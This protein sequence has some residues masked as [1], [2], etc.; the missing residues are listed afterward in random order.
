M[1][2][3]EE[4]GVKAVVR[5]YSIEV[6]DR[7]P[8]GHPAYDLGRILSSD[9]PGDL[10]SLVH[11]WRHF[12]ENSD[13]E[14]P[15]NPV[16]ED[17]LV[18]ARKLRDKWMEYHDNCS[19]EDRLDLTTVEPTMEGIVGVVDAALAVWNKKRRKGWRGE[20]ASNFHKFCGT[21]DS[22]SNMLGILPKENMYVTIFSGSLTTIIK[23][24]ARNPHRAAFF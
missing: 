16:T 9:G 19:D 18:E 14:T 6:N 24:S 3:S 5:M 7:L 4:R 17:V 1:S 22:H 21:L 11:P 15:K 2:S 20:A 23:V 12:F 8:I 10:R 13:H